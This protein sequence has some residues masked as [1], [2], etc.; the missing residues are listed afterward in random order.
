MHVAIN[1]LSTKKAKR[2]KRVSVILCILLGFLVL[3]SF[4]IKRY[5]LSAD[6]D[7][8]YS[9]GL[10]LLPPYATKKPRA[11]ILDKAG[12]VL[13][14]SQKRALIYAIPTQISNLLDTSKRLSSILN[15][16]NKKIINLLNSSKSNICIIKEDIKPSIANLIKKLNLAGI[17]VS[18]YYKR[19]YPY[20]DIVNNVI[21]S[22]G[23]NGNGI[24]G[25]EYFYNNKLKDYRQIKNLT[26]GLDLDIESN[27]QRLL[28]WQMERLRAKTGCFL[29]MNLK[30]D[31]II[32]MA[33][34]KREK[35]HFIPEQLYLKANISPVIMWPIMGL[36]LSNNDK[37]QIFDFNNSKSWDLFYRDGTGENIVFWGP[38]SHDTINNIKIKNSKNSLVSILARLGFGQK[39][40]IDLP[41]EDAGYLMPISE[42]N[43]LPLVFK[44]TKAS[45]IQLL[46]AFTKVLSDQ[47]NVIPHIVIHRKSHLMAKSA[48]FPLKTIASFKKAISEK[49]GISLASILFKGEDDSKFVSSKDPAQ[50]VALGFYPAKDPQVVYIL[51]LNDATRDPRYVKG[52]LAQSY[53]IAR[54]ASQNILAQKRIKKRL[55]Y[56][57]AS[58]EKERD[59]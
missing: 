23:P 9:Q 1:K 6:A 34:Y 56:F 57:V 50:V 58:I 45:A 40:G 13:A 2:Q 42:P 28:K 8:I 48:L 12:A 54:R 36:I 17:G 4:L 53:L 3:F 5:L 11:T 46:V 29:M 10:L 44:N 32:A 47:N 7:Q 38:F 15:I 55:R 37:E 59:S 24:S 22:I 31:S 14:I 30:D 41:D 43:L 21:G 35:W 26:L 49:H 27:S 33:S 18:Y 25:I 16:S 20:K 19:I 52:V 51:V 39:T